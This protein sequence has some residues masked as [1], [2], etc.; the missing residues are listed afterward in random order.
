MYICEHRNFTKMHILTSL[1]APELE[2]HM[3][4]VLAKPTVEPIKSTPLSEEEEKSNTSSLHRLFSCRLKTT[5]SYVMNCALS[6]LVLCSRLRWRHSRKRLRV[7]S[8][9]ALTSI[10]SLYDQIS[11]PTIITRTPTGRY[12]WNK[13]TRQHKMKGKS[14][15]NGKDCWVMLRIVGPANFNYVPG[16]HC[17]V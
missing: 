2:V 14:T 15:Q 13:A 3:A 17:W 4:L 7:S 8:G 9:S 11:K 16:N 10:W 12:S 6:C 1:T 5:A